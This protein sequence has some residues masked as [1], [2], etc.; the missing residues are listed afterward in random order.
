MVLFCR[1]PKPTLLFCLILLFFCLL[2]HCHGSR[3]TSAFKFKPK[4]EHNKGHFL[5]FL[6]RRIHIPY[7][8]PSRK[9]N[10]IGLTWRSP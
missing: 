2:G 4:S 3:T 8:S 7:S 6:P 5:G 10:D 9:H 1:R